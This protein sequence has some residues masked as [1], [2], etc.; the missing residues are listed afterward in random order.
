[1]SE[2][3]TVCEKYA[4]M[5]QTLIEQDDSLVNI[6]N[7]KA[8]IAYLSSDLAKTDKGRIVYGQCEK[9][10]DKY[11]WGIDA[12]F[13]IT[14]FDPNLEGKSDAIIERVLFHELLHVGVE[15]AP[16]GGERYSVT[17]HDLEDFKECIDRW[18]TS[19]VEE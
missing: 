8:K 2:T 13:M 6:R 12:D 7:S 1:M 14:L 11:K 9:V 15:F 17:P 4:E 19:W 16:D 18:G 3:R 5:A 10:A